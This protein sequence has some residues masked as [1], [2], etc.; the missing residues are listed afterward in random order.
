MS[1]QLSP[2]ARV[3]LQRAVESG[4]SYSIHGL[5]L[6]DLVRTADLVLELQ[7][8]RLVHPVPF[9]RERDRLVIMVEITEAGRRTLAS[10]E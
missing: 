6:R 2:E 1:P 3:I 8:F 4:G 10:D 7:R 5:P 9:C